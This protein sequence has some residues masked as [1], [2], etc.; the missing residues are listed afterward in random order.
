MFVIGAVVSISLLQSVLHDLDSMKSEAV[1]G[2]V[3]SVREDLER[4]EAGLMANRL[5]TA[6]DVPA[7]QSNLA[8]VRRSM[9]V[10]LNDAALISA[11]SAD[12]ADAERI[13]RLLTTL[14]EGVAGSPQASVFGADVVAASVALHSELD[15][16]AT[17]AIRN[18]S[19]KQA[20]LSRLLRTLIIGL[21]VA[22]LLSTNVAIYVL[23]RTANMILQPVSALI[24]GSRELAKEHFD[25]RV[26][27]K[28]HDEFEELAHA[29]NSLA[30]QLR[31]NEERK[32]MALQQLAVTLN[33]EFNNVINIIELR[34]KLLDKR[35]SGD[36]KLT[37]HIDEIHQNL[38]R[39]SQTIVSLQHVRRVAVTSYMPGQLMLDLPR[40]IADDDEAAGAPAA[41]ASG[42]KE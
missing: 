38:K 39:M 1:T 3:Q 15:S 7:M 12:P 42:S 30:E 40:C 33:H 24:E 18:V 11:G 23:V 28:Q 16:L 14:Q 6:T 26:R 27:V 13:G 35:A 4:F 37:S 21:T 19:A 10:L 25:Y 2:R 32:V 36:P 5:G 8:G 9:N 34:L 31:A 41:A 20:D 22:A 17:I 29:Y